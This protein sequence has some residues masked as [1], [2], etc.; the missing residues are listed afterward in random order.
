[1]ETRLKNLEWCQT[2]YLLIPLLIWMANN[3]GVPSSPI[4]GT[5]RDPMMLL[6]YCNITTNFTTYPSQSSRQ[7]QGPESYLEGLSSVQYQH[8]WPAFM[9][10]PHKGHG[11]P[12]MQRISPLPILRNQDNMSWL[13]NSN[14]QNWVCYTSPII[15]YQKKQWQIFK[16]NYYSLY[17]VNVA[18]TTTPTILLCIHLESWEVIC[19]E[20]S[21]SNKG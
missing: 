20:T 15:G 16:R 7:W 3:K 8:D 11:D 14:L 1:M 5:E 21:M 6:Y 10:R 17:W 2:R 4:K 19:S 12:R 18:S 13:T 9:P